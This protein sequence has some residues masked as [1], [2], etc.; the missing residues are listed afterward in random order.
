MRKFN[1]L[2]E[3]ILDYFANQR[4]IIVFALLQVCTGVCLM[5]FFHKYYEIAQLNLFQSNETFI[6]SG[7]MQCCIGLCGLQAAW[8]RKVE[9]MKVYLGVLSCNVLLQCFMLVPVSL[10]SCVCSDYVQ[11]SVLDT[12]T[13]DTGFSDGQWH[14]PWEPPERHH[15]EKP[16]NETRRLAEF[17]DAKPFDSADSQEIR[18]SRPFTVHLGGDT[19]SKDVDY[20]KFRSRFP[21][22]T[23]SSSM[24]SSNAS[25]FISGGDA[26]MPPRLDRASVLMAVAGSAVENLLN[27]VYDSHNGLRRVAKRGIRLL[28]T[29]D[30]EETELTVIVD[31]CDGGK[32]YQKYENV[33][34]YFWVTQKDLGWN[35]L[36]ANSVDRRMCKEVQEEMEI[37]EAI[38]LKE[39]IV[40]MKTYQLVYMRPTSMFRQEIN[41]VMWE[42]AF[43]YYCLVVKFS[44]ETP[45]DEGRG[46][47][48]TAIYR[49][50]SCVLRGHVW[51]KL[52]SEH[53][54]GSDIHG[55]YISLWVQ[56]NPYMSILARNGNTW[57]H[58]RNVIRIAL[59]FGVLVCLSTLFWTWIVHAFLAER[60]GDRITVDT[61]FD[62]NSD[63]SSD[64]GMAAFEK[65]GRGSVDSGSSI[66]LADRVQT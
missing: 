65:R 10:V 34:E 43:T 24:L 12:F 17:M 6:V 42:C 28:S 22:S 45:Q 61:Q 62:V 38:A 19:L 25:G 59:C 7:F 21:E 63:A 32:E 57:Q 64:N 50:R 14:N 56:K 29:Y 37:S 49:L 41:R 23:V 20:D 58:C 33:F 11:C 47:K 15:Q 48:K 30:E 36:N 55:M 35:E 60:C 5:W 18:G 3:R 54:E 39:E 16:G 51:P 44:L 2:K 52:E 66:E 53:D 40:A 13:E 46:G 27:V 8:L 31:Q 9:T 26:V 4:S 1:D